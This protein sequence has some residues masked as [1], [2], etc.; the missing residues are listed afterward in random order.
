MHGFQCIFT[1]DIFAL[2]ILS[3]ANP[4]YLEMLGYIKKN[5]L[6]LIRVRLLD[7]VQITNQVFSSVAQEFLQVKECCN[8]H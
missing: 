4:S 7:P 8:L 3:N 6:S 2:D 5:T 1:L